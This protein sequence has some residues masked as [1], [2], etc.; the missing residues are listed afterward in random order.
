M[1]DGLGVDKDFLDNGAMMGF[2]NLENMG[3]LDNM[4]EMLQRIPEEYRDKAEEMF[5]QEMSNMGGPVDFKLWIKLINLQREFNDRVAP[6]WEKD[7]K[8]EKFNYWTAILDETVEVVGSK[9]W[10][11]WKDSDRMNQVDWDNVNVELIDLFHFLLSVS[12]QH[13]QQDIIFMT[14]IAYEKNLEDSKIKIRDEKFFDEFWNEFLMAVWQ[15]SLPLLVVKWCEFF[16]RSGGDF[17]SLTRSYFIKNALNHIRQEFG[18][19]EGKYKK[20]WRNPNNPSILV[21]DN[22]VA[23]LLL[24]GTENLT[25]DTV[26]EMQDTLRRYY[27]E[28]IVI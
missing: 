11:W 25:E 16:Y 13:K 21:E 23:G 8:Q 15:K 4:G 28:F 2:S 19:A 24:N 26:T 12:I 22:V 6:G 7:L 17:Q 5:D 27:L 3:N 20:M 18:Y 14:L 9:H 10:K 1:F